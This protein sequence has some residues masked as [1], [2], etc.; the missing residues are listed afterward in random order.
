MWKHRANL[1]I[2]IYENQNKQNILF[3]Y[4]SIST[5]ISVSN[6]P[7]PIFITIKPIPIR[8][9]AQTLST[10]VLYHFDIF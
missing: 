7:T 4:R 1:Q 10:I 6:K 9:F 5:R 3:N 8:T 2:N